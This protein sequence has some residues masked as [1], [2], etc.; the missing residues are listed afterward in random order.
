[1]TETTNRNITGS[2][3]LERE[4]ANIKEKLQIANDLRVKWLPTN[5]RKSGEVIGTTI[6]IYEEDLEK[7]LNTLKHEF[8][9]YIITCEWVGPYKKLVNKFISLFEEEIYERKEKLIDKILKLI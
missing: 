8:I 4:L 5:N 1:M 7:A 2:S 6:Y 9:E 3:R